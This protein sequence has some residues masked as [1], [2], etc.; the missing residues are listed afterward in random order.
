MSGV[1]RFAV[2][3]AVALVLHLAGT[4]LLPALPRLVDFFLVFLVAQG[5]STG[6][7]L[8]MV[9]GLAAGLVADGLSGG[10]FG[11]FGLA[12]TVVGYGSAFV[13]QRLVIQRA[14]SALAL[15]VAAAVI[16]QAILLAVVALLLPQPRGPDWLGVVSKA[17]STGVLGMLFFGAQ[18]LTRRR[19]ESWQQG[20]PS[21][22][23]LRR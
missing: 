6:P 12:G 2:G 10:P 18:R 13:A 7:V 1:V 8:G 15:F 14:T 4:R 19:Y 23:R 20:R 16:Q 11:L 9:G 3:L 22:L 21:R 17:A 5:M